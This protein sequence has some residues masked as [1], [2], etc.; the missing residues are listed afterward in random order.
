M[1]EIVVQIGKDIDFL[2]TVNRAGAVTLAE[3]QRFLERPGK[4]PSRP[5]TTGLEAGCSLLHPHRTTGLDRTIDRSSTSPQKKPDP[6]VHQQGRIRL[7]NHLLS[8]AYWPSPP[9][10]MLAA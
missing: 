10:L 8:W 9:E 3:N 5:Q 7:A 6:A 4:H 2:R 1:N